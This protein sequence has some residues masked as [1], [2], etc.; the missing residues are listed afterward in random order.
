MVG[1][2]FQLY[3]RTSKGGDKQNQEQI[4]IQ[5][6]A[7]GESS[8]QN[9]GNYGVTGSTPKTRRTSYSRD[10]PAG[11][12][13]VRVR[14]AGQNTDGSGAQATF[15]WTSLTSVQ[16]DAASYAGI[17]RIGVKMKATGQLNGAPDELRGRVMAVHTLA[18]LGS[19]PVWAFV[20]GSAATIAGGRVAILLFA[21]L[22][23][24]GLIG[25]ARAARAEAVLVGDLD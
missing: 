14:V 7:V 11:Q 18:T 6:R 21:I 15:T 17:A 9:L 22:A 2:E 1:I 8:W 25:A 20:V 19:R 3:D 16:Q 12:Y 4:Q 13:D 10:V 5:Y 24:V 23:P